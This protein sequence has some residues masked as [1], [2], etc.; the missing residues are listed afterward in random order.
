MIKF[1]SVFLIFSSIYLLICI[2][3]VSPENIRNNGVLH[4][5]TVVKAYEQ[6]T[7]GGTSSRHQ[8]SYLE[9]RLEDGTQKILLVNSIEPFT[10]GEE[11]PLWEYKGD[12]FVDKYGNL[13]RPDPLIAI[14]VF[15][16]SVITIVYWKVFRRQTMHGEK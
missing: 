13:E 16:L 10:V 14:I 8:A 1:A 5:G 12:L 3:S 2:F 11:I 9:V 4:H 15:V 7:G 6:L